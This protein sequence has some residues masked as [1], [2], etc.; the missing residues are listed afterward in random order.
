MTSPPVTFDFFDLPPRYGELQTQQGAM[1]E[2]EA[3][4]RQE[5]ESLGE[6]IRKN[7]L[8]QGDNQNLRAEAER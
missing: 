7:A 6:E 8:V 5:R 1:E 4:L 2:L 3:A